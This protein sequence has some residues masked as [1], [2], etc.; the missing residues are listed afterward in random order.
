MDANPLE[1]APDGEVKVIAAW[2]EGDMS[3]SF[4]CFQYVFDMFLYIIL[5]IY[6]FSFSFHTLRD[7]PLVLCWQARWRDEGEW[8][9]DWMKRLFFF[10]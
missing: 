8:L 2:L 3:D 10:V 7:H 1:R 5:Y 6:V 9:P 4:Y